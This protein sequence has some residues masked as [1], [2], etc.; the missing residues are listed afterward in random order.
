MAT[1]WIP[2]ERD[3]R[4]GLDVKGQLWDLD[5]MFAQASRDPG[6]RPAKPIDRFEGHQAM[7]DLTQDV[8]R[9]EAGQVLVLDPLHQLGAGRS[10]G[11]MVGEVVNQRIRIEEDRRRGRDLGEGHGD[12][13]TLNSS[14]SA[15]RRRTSGS[16]VH[17]SIPAVRSA[18]LSCGSMVMRTVSCSFS[19]SGWAGLSTPFS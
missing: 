3:L 4:D 1:A 15:I 10:E 12:S 16:P 14:S 9:D 7:G 17:L 5:V 13:S 8:R 11:G 2:S 19:G 6:R 18:Q